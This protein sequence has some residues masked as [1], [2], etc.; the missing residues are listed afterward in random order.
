MSK[1]FSLEEADIVP[2]RGSR[3]IY[4]Q[5]IEEYTASGL[6]TVKVNMP[7]KAVKTIQIGLLK[8]VKD[9]GLSGKLSVII[10]DGV[11]YITPKV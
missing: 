3:G 6:E 7:G 11:A 9:A 1:L 5:V 2:S 8:A 4:A 10:R